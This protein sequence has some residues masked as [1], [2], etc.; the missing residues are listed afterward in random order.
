MLQKQKKDWLLLLFVFLSLLVLCRE[1]LR[2][3]QFRFET[4]PRRATRVLEPSLAATTAGFFYCLLLFFIEVA[5]VEAPEEDF[6]FCGF[7]PEFGEGVAQFFGYT[8]A[9]KEPAVTLQLLR[10][11]F[12]CRV[13]LPRQLQGQPALAFEDRSHGLRSSGWRDRPG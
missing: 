7:V 12:S 11:C 10:C 4:V 6:F 3:A 9:Q 5:E 8:H 2:V 13:L 1:L